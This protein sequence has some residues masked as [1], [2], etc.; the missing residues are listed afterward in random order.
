MLG[1]GVTPL[2]IFWIST[3]AGIT[4]RPDRIAYP[5]T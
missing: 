1:E 2:P 3:G 4:G 5:V